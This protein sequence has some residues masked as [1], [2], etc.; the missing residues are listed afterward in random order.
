MTAKR[1]NHLLTLVACL[2]IAA[3]VS[4]AIGCKGTDKKQEL[5]QLISQLE[6]Y[7]LKHGSYPLNL[8]SISISV[9]DDVHYSVDS[10]RHNFNLAY[11]EGA[12]DVI[13]FHIVVRHRNGRKDLTTE[14]MLLT[15]AL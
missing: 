2:I 15:R 12:M 6:K 4:F 3:A 13:L 7:K 5:S 8:D 11:T 1:N 10:T 9:D 14:A